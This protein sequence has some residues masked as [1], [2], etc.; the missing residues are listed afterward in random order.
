MINN[1]KLPLC[2]QSS[3]RLGRGFTLIELLVVIAI[4]AILAAILFPAFAK[5]RESARRTSCSSNLKQIGIGLLQYIGENDERL[6]AS[7]YGPGGTTAASNATTNY[8]WMDAIYP[9]VK[10]EAL[11]VCPSDSNAKY[12]YNRNIPIGQ[13]S[14]DYGSYGQNGAYR[15]AG[16]NQTP[17]R[18]STYTIA[19]SQIAV[20]SGT[21]WAT[22][23]NNREEANG[24]FGFT[25]PDAATVPPLTIISGYRQLDK[26]TERHLNTTNVLWCDGHVKS[27]KLDTLMQT[28][29]VYCSPSLGT[30]PVM[31]VFTIEDD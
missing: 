16:D 26:I 2:R 11:F 19:L 3:T 23:T 22:D 4:I 13:S 1:L 7:A 24:S 31:T 18:S 5:A 12:V 15:N 28:K 20:P 27:V 29:P 8:K 25:W 21:V 6:P 17:P 10:S 9:Y 14:T 30:R